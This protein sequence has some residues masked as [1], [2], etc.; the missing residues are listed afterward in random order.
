MILY[1]D[2]VADL[3][4]YGHINFLKNIYLQKKEGDLLYV[5]IHSDKTTE[6]YKDVPI[7]SMEER[8]KVVEAC[9]YLDKVITDSPITITKEFID[10]HKIDLIF[11]PDNRTEDEI[12]LML[13]VP[14]QMGIVRKVPYTNT[15][16][17]TD[18]IKRI[19]KRFDK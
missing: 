2:M 6:S 18:I 14:Y 7:M 16:S 9:K 12:K 1:T 19:S 15:I 5:G 3:F 8:I 10:L 11:T 17:T 4:H 13:E